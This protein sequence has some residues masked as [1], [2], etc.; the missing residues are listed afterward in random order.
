MQK[1]RVVRALG[2]GSMENWMWAILL[3]PLFAVVV[4]FLLYC[5]RR[6][7]MRFMPPGRLKRI[8]LTPLGRSQKAD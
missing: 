1:A 6:G 4:L 2:G 7:V 3:K 5:C 8:F